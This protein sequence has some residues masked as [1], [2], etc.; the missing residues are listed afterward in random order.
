MTAAL[1]TRTAVTG[2][3]RAATPTT[4]VVRRCAVCGRPLLEGDAPCRNPL[5]ASA[6]R[7]FHWNVAAADR[8]G[9][10]Q[11]AL[12]AYKYQGVLTWAP[13]FGRMLAALLERRHRLFR[14]FDLITSSPTFVGRGGRDFD[15]VRLML[16]EATRHAPADHAWPFDTAPVAA[17]VKCRP[18]PRLAPLDHA[19]RRRVA[20]EHLR[21]ALHVPDRGRTAGRRILVVDDVFTD[22]RTLDEV[23][24]ALRLRGGAREVCGLTL[25]RQPWYERDREVSDLSSRL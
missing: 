4:P 24:R 17:I 20:A 14:P 23:A 6:T 1:T 7:W 22:G 3:Q 15:H 25:C 5:C 18:T 11:A 13:V 21:P 12:D 10:L 16:A 2:A 9:P 19:E 8:S